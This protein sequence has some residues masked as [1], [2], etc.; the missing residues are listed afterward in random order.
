MVVFHKCVGSL[1]H[2]KDVFVCGGEKA[3]IS[4]MSEAQRLHYWYIQGKAH[5]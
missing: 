1:S 2:E 4:K 3:S 5:K